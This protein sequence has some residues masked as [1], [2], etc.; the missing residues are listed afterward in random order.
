[1]KNHDV[2]DIG[3]KPWEFLSN[4]MAYFFVFRGF[5]ISCMEGLIQALKFPLLDKQCRVMTLVGIK[6]KRKG[7]KKKWYLDHILY[8]QGQPIDRF[9]KEYID[10][11]E[12]A[13]VCM[14]EQNDKFRQALLATG[15][16]KLIHSHGKSDPRYTVLT[17]DEFVSILTRLRDGEIKTKIP[18]RHKTTGKFSTRTEL[19]DVIFSSYNN[20]GISAGMIAKNT[21]V[22]LGIVTSL[23]ESIEHLIWRS[24]SGNVLL[25]PEQNPEELDYITHRCGEVVITLLGEK[26]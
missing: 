2:V 22:S 10:L 19:L 12:E 24:I 13:F 26:L 14:F 16:K 15:T 18:K 25:K 20:S 6:A 7:Q 8:W 1:M 9:S 23:L 3:E 11:I 21:S 17:E 4:F 5:E